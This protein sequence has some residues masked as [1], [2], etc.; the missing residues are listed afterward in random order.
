MTRMTRT[1]YW[2]PNVN[3]VGMNSAQNFMKSKKAKMIVAGVR[4]AAAGCSCNC[5]SGCSSCSSSCGS[6]TSCSTSCS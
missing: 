6:C 1:N 4:V 2:N 5:S 3:Y